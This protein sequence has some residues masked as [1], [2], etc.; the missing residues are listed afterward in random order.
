MGGG[1]KET[2]FSAVGKCRKNQCSGFLGAEYME[3]L[4]ASL[5]NAGRKRIYF[6]DVFLFS[7]FSIVVYFYVL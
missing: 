6:S 3:E 4:L 7:L 2:E 1:K 5:G